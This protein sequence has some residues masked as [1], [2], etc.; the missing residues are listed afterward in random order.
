VCHYLQRG[1][2]RH[3]SSRAL[4]AYCGAISGRHACVALCQAG[5]AI[6]TGK[7]GAG[8]RGVEPRQ[9]CR[10]HGSRAFVKER[11]IA[12]AATTSRAVGT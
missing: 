2:V 8:V 7:G 4:G 9:L 11:G 10:F 1:R 12:G 5:G 3:A 6:V